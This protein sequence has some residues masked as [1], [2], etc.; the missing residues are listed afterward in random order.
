LQPSDDID[1]FGIAKIVGQ[2]LKPKGLT[3]MPARPI[4]DPGR[5]LSASRSPVRY[6]SWWRIL[7]MLAATLWLVS[8]DSQSPGDPQSGSAAGPT[9]PP[10]EV[11]VVKVTAQSVPLTR[12]LVGRLA[13][14]RVAEVRARVAGIIL[15]QVYTE[16]TDVSAGEVLFQIDPAHL[17]VTVHGQ[18]AALAKARADADIASNIAER[19]STLNQKGLIS[20]QDLD[21]ALAAQLST[22]AQVKIAEANLEAA[23][24]DLDYA[25][26]RAPIAGRAGRARVNEGALVGENEATVLTTVEQVDPIRINFS[27]SPAEL[28]QLQRIAGRATGSASGQK[29]VVDVYLQSGQVYPH[30]GSLDFTDLAVDP[31]TGAV[32]LR[33]VAPNPDRRLLPGMFVKLRLTLGLL[34]GAYVVPQA[35]VLRDAQGAYV[36]IVND[37]GSVEQKRIELHTSADSEWVVT[38][39]LRDGDQVIVA[40]LQK[41]RPG[42]QARIASPGAKAAAGEQQGKQ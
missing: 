33:A 10:A 16:G 6:F 20:R 17:E 5:N 35:S 21:N 12:E 23:R 25:T 39:D 22:A 7:T 1:C 14:S 18:Q 13:S 32:S 9:P 26:V 38:G 36:L 27:Q 8:C 41:V 30:K 37:G 19:Y 15:K 11:D 29:L 24:L 42:G 34:Q 4:A 28:E 31:G 40:G 2:K 3:F